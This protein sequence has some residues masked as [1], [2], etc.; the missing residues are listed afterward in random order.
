MYKQNENKI[1]KFKLP[2]IT[3]PIM[4]TIYSKTSLYVFP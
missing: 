3:P 1:S 2:I 4:S